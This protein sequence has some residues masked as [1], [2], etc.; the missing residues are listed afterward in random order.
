MYEGKYELLK[1]TELPEMRLMRY[2]GGTSQ[3]N[4]DIVDSHRRRTGFKRHVDLGRRTSRP[5][6]VTVEKTPFH[7]SLDSHLSEATLNECNTGFA[8]DHLRPR[9]A[10]PLKRAWTPLELANT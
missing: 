3:I 8:D 1:G 4:L 6:S 5:W 7:F 9:G 2:R 10:A